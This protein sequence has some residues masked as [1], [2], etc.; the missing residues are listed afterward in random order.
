[1]I[2]GP[3]RSVFIIV[4]LDYLGVYDSLR[5]GL[6]SILGHKEVVHRQDQLILPS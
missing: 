4:F 5:K 6:A 1:M 2:N 3:K